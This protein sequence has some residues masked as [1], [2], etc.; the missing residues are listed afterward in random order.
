M[1]YNSQTHEI[2]RCVEGYR[3]FMA[4]TGYRSMEDCIADYQRR[5][6]ERMSPPGSSDAMR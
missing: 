4:G 6:Y 3:S 2:A 1:M 5:G